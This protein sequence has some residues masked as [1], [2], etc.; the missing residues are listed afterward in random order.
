MSAALSLV[1]MGLA[2]ALYKTASTRERA[3]DQWNTRVARALDRLDQAGERLNQAVFGLYEE[4][5][6]RLRGSKGHEPP[7]SPDAS[8]PVFFSD[9][10]TKGR[11][12]PAAGEVTKT[13]FVGIYGSEAGRG[14]EGPGVARFKDASPRPEPEARIHI[15]HD[16][17]IDAVVQI[18]NLAGETT[19][20]E[21]GAVL[22]NRCSEQELL[23]AVG[24]ARDAG[25]LSWEAPRDTVRSRLKGL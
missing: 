8:E 6:T 10:K 7:L 17:L 24:K 1:A 12:G 15:V 4:S 13:A 11:Q 16:T 14:R 21:L 19:V 22:K 18:V 3:S 5:L 20:R 25:I 2:L 9:F 23:E